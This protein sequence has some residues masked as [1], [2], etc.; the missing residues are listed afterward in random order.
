MLVLTRKRNEEIVIGDGIQLKVLRIKGNR[1]QIGI[2]AAGDVR[3][4][5]FEKHASPRTVEFALPE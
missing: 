4:E 5:R 3:I 2:T 1:V